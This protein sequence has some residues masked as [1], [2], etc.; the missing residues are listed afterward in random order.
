M[1]GKK[2]GLGRGLDALFPEKKENNKEQSAVTGKGK[3]EKTEKTENVS[4]ET[5]VGVM[6][7]ISKVEPNRSQPR[8]K[9]S[10]DSLRELAESIKQCGVLQPILAAAKAASTPAWPAPITSTS[11]SPAKNSLSLTIYHLILIKTTILI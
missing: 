2:T 8:K 3:V 4:R 10:E 6:V 1:A 7:K 11:Y 5:T 9:F